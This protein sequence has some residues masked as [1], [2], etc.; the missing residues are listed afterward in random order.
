[1]VEKSMANDKRFLQVIK[2]V[3]LGIGVLLVITYAVLSYLEIFGVLEY[4]TSWENFAL[5]GMCCFCLSMFVWQRLEMDA[6]EEEQDKEI[7][8]LEAELAKYKS[9]ETPETTDEK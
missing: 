1:M 9:A 5:F 4:E 6:Q 3:L 7:A 2:W 8:E